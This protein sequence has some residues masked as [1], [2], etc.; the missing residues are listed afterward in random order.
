MRNRL[1]TKIAASLSLLLVFLSS[2]T[3]S[4][5]DIPGLSPATPTSPFPIPPTGTPQPMAEIT[6]DV[7]LPLPLLP[8]ETLVLSVLDEVTGLGLNPA[9]YPMSGRDAVHYTVTVPFAPGSVVKYR[10]MRTGGLPVSEDDSADSAVRYRLYHVTGPGAVQDVVSGWSDSPFAGP[11]GRISGQVVDAGSGSAVPNILVT[12]GGQRTL[13]DSTGAF[14]LEGLPPGTH[15]LVAYALDGTYLTFQQGA[16]VEAGRRTPVN[17]ALTH[18]TMVNVIF[19]VVV[20]ANTITGVPVRLAGNLYA[21]GNT[22]GDLDGGM[23]SVASRM[24]TLTPLGD[25]R[26][27]TTLSLPAGADIRYKYTLGDGFWNAEHRADGDFVVRQLIVPQGQPTLLVEDLVET[28]QA[29]NSAPILFEVSVPAETPVGDIISIQFNPY[30]WTEPVPMWPMGNNRWAYQLYSPL[31]MLGSFEYRYCRNDQCGVAD[32]VETS[33]GRRGRLIATSLTAQDLQDTVRAWTWVQAP[34]AGQV[35]GVPVTPRA[36]GFWV[37]IEFLA[38]YDP[39][40]QA[41]MT[42]ALQN[43]RGLNANM[44][45]LAPSW[46]VSR[47]APFTFAP[48]PGNDPLWADTRETVS[49]ARA[50]NLNVALFPQPNLPA[51]AANWW[52]TAPRDPV[53]WETWF[54]RYQAFVLYHAD[55]ATGAD[56]QVLILGGDWLAPA[57]PGGLVGGAASGVPADAATRWSNLLIALRSRFGGQVYW[58]VSY[59]GGLGSAPAFLSGLDGVYVL[60]NAP[61]GASADVVSMQAEAG[62]LMDGDL[63]PFAVALQK[64]LIIAVAVPSASG[65]TQAG[66]PEAVLFTPG[67]TGAA[68]DLQVQLDMYQALLGAVNERP[69]LGG[70]VSRGYYPPAVLQDASASIHGKLAAD[71][72]WYWYPRLQ[73][74]T[75]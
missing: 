5:I 57:L 62:R 4:L 46:T 43:V 21:L 1:F 34:A 73:G 42:P 12:A 32:D 72:L 45:V 10:Y 7:T 35:V 47:T 59:P 66:L 51:E 39:T 37:G 31:N 13:T 71:V 6:F 20:P 36:P 63:L 25:G 74:L 53:W 3:F 23:S 67:S 49:R 15:N 55:L 75:P 8:G 70:F 18:A 65:A 52:A 26:Y 64:P 38:D 61:L 24:P 22:F 30:G 48:L 41:W 58:A 2:C 68:V 50:L 54:E 27:T 11:T 14:L 40:W 17:V 16:R 33:A 29:G 56:A 60:W 44:V 28:W 19:T 69:W 9:N